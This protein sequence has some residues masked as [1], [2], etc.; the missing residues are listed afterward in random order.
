MLESLFYRAKSGASWWICHLTLRGGC[1]AGIQGSQMHIKLKKK[2]KS[3]RKQ[4]RGE[5]ERRREWLWQRGC[6]GQF[7]QN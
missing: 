4:I 5:L 2:E 7:A 3:K 6:C 1:A